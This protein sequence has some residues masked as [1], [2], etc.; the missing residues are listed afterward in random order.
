MEAHYASYVTTE[1]IDKLASVGVNS[2]RIP[3]TYTA[4]IDV[5][6]AQLYHNSQQA[7]LKAT[8]DYAVSK[9]GMRIVVG[10][11]SLPGGVNT[12]DIGEA[13]GHDAW[14]FNETNLDYSYKAVSAI[15]GFIEASRNP[16]AYTVGL[17]NEASDN[18][19]DF[20]TPNTL[21]TAGTEWIVMY[22]NGAFDL[23]AGVDKKIPIMLQDCFIGE[24]HWSPY[25]V[26]GSNLVNGT[27]IY[28]FAASGIYSRYTAPATCGQAPAAGGDGK[29]P[30]FIGEW[31]LQVLYDNE[32]A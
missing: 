31:S 4:W 15:L 30:V 22:T 1:T 7:H 16:W 17:I 26:Q 5:P 18:F 29:L 21:T 19:A 23:V 9:H 8:C 13:F 6:G 25:F 27:H 14:F 20:A 28:Y 11:H 12:L 32:Y 2:L 10:L 24:E 3:T